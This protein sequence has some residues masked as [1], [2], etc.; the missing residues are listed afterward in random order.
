MMT[1]ALPALRVGDLTIEGEVTQR[2]VQYDKTTTPTTVTVCVS[3][4]N[5][6]TIEQTGTRNGMW[7]GIDLIEPMPCLVCGEENECEHDG[8]EQVR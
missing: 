4:D 2:S 5:G 1:V 6:A 8:M 3:F 7:A